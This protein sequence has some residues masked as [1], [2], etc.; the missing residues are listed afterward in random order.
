MMQ[1]GARMVKVRASGA[2]V[3]RTYALSEC[4]EFLLWTPS[5]H[6][7]DRLA[8]ASIKEMRKGC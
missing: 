6:G 4:K 3:A 2:P 1:R 7:H 5:T 8:I